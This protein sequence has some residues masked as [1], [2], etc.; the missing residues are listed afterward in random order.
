MNHISNKQSNSSVIWTSA[1]IG[2]LSALVVSVIGSVICT[3][4]IN[5]GNIG[6]GAYSGI[7]VVL[8][9]LS[10]LIGTMTACKKASKQCF[11]LSIITS[12]GYIM[13]LSGVQ[14]LLFNSE[15]N[16]IWRGILA[17]TAGMIPTILSCKKAEG[18]NKPKIKYRAV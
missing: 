4:F 6:E 12:I 7:A 3:F 9:F 15:F 17:I 1:L 2:V 16:R 10:S 18:R 5:T 11:L 8:W 14:I 13:V